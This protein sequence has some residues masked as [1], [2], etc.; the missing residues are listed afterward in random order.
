MAW[1]VDIVKHHRIINSIENNGIN[2]M[3]AASI[4]TLWA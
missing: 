4:V 1:R 2:V 3:A